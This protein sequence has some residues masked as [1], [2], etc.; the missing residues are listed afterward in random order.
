MQAS[1]PDS[2]ERVLSGVLRV[3]DQTY[4]DETWVWD[5]QHVQSPMDVIAGAV[6]VQHTTWT[7]ASRALDQLRSAGALDAEKLAAM[8]DEALL[9]LVRVSGT[10]TVKARRLQAIAQTI[11]DAGGLEAFLALPLAELRTRLIATHGVGPETADAIMLYAANQPTFVIDAYTQRLFRRIGIGPEKDGYDSWQ[12]WFDERLP[13]DA[14]A[15]QRHHAH[16][17]LHGK[18]LCRTKP[19]CSA[20]PLSSHCAYAA[21]LHIPASGV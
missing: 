9:P 4:R 3:L 1:L 10:P 13:L 19:R 11:L 18:A 16:I 17:V 8:P 15:F 12:R 2:P 21:T 5:P 6:L 20:C 7:N 14:P